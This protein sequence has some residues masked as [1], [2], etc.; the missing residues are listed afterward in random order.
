MPI[1]PSTTA[2]DFFE[3][4]QEQGKSGGILD[5][6][7]AIMDDNL[8]DPGP[9]NSRLFKWLRAEGFTGTLNNMIDQFERSN[10]V[11]HG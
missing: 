5:Q 3:W 6:L 7:D 2:H 8:V 1:T 4:V 10:T 9:T 11:Q